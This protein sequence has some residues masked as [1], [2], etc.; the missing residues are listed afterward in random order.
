MMLPAGMRSPPKALTPRRFAWESRPLRELPPA[1]LCAMPHAPYKLSRDADDL[2]FSVVLPVAVRFAIVLAAAHLEHMHC[3]AAPAAHDVRR[4]R[5]AAD[6]RRTQRDVLAV[7]EEQ[8]LVEHDLGPDV[9]R[10]LFYFQ[11]FT[12]GHAILLA[13]GLDDRIHG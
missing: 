1:F 9:C 5:R 12:G 4:H 10:Y 11:F 13:A 8:H 2:D 7:R 3:L 6:E